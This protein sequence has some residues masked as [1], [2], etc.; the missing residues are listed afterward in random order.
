[1]DKTAAERAALH[2][3][4]FRFIEQNILPPPEETVIDNSAICFLTR[5]PLDRRIHL[6]RLKATVSEI[7]YSIRILCLSDAEL[8]PFVVIVGTKKLSKGRH[9]VC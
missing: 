5:I 4:R 6:L 2:F 7:E 1:L 3:R 9:C 8:P